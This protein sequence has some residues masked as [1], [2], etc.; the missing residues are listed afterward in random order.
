MKVKRMIKE[1]QKCNPEAEVKL[2]G[3]LGNNA[4][5]VLS[6]VGDDKNVV[7]EDK[8]DANLTSELEARYE[9]ACEEQ[10]DELNFYMDLF[11]MGFTLEDIKE[12]L[13]E[14]YEQSKIFCE[15]HGL[16]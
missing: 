16:A 4:L 15:D 11:E 9:K 6:Y 1:L 13:P 2:H 14:K 7:I 10:T 3:K 8:D 5:F 12:N